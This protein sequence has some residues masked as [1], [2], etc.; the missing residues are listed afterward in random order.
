MEVWIALAI[1]EAIGALFIVRGGYIK[2][3]GD[4]NAIDS[5]FALFSAVLFLSALCWPLWAFSKRNR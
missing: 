2:R 4:R 1:W 3:D 5:S